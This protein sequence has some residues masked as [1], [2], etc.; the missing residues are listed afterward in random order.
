MKITSIIV[1]VCLLS[2]TATRSTPIDSVKKVLDNARWQTTVTK[3]YDAA[4]VCI[5]YPGGDVSIDRGVC[6]DVVVRAFRAVNIDFQKLIHEDMQK[7]FPAYPATWG[8]KKPDPNIDHRRVPNI[9]RYLKRTG[10]EVPLSMNC[11]DY[12]PGDIVTWILPGDLDHI[13]LVS[14]ILVDSTGCFKVFH[15]IGNGAVVEDVLFGFKITGHYRYFSE[16]R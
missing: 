3:Y 8:L 7:H 13:G 6:T 5:P 10:K 2:F 14:S 1:A 11:R 16:R 15:N 9:A 4:Y 12:R